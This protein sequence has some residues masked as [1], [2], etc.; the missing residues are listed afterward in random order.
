MLILAIAAL[1][2]RVVFPY[3]K[4]QSEAD[5]QAEPI[6]PSFE[7]EQTGP[8]AIEADLDEEPPETKV[9]TPATTAPIPDNYVK[10]LQ[11]DETTAPATVYEMPAVKVPTKLINV[12]YIN[13]LALYP[14]GCESVSAVM[15]LN[16]CGYDISVDSFIDNYLDKSVAPYI[17]TDNKY[18][19][20]DPNEYFLGDPYSETGWGCKAPVIVKALNRCIYRDLHTVE[21]LSGAEL[22][23]LKSYIDR[24]IPVIV[25]ATQG[26]QKTR[27]SKTWTVVGTDRQYTWTAPNHC[28][29][30]VG[31]DDTGYYFND[32]LTHANCR[33]EAD[34]AE[35][36]YNAMGK[37]AIAIIKT[38]AEEDEIYEQPPEE[39][40]PPL[41]EE[42][43]ISPP[44]ADEND[45]NEQ[46]IKNSNQLF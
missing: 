41:P 23:S 17:G 12:N 43:E 39:N 26:M 46:D 30:L 4:A 2:L 15:A 27:T 44:D 18:Y 29:L 16:Y 7:L 25:W 13:Q 32:P 8:P 24:D 35:S 1:A 21:N 10:A 31:Y 9:T 11:K 14:S 45:N 19:G 22:S 36:R 42:P 3:G 40:E 5:K 37:Q 33:Y 6:G 28:L 20:Y 38:E 34:I